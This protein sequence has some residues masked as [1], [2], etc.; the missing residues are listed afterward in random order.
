MLHVSRRV[1]ARVTAQ[2]AAQYLLCKRWRR[3]YIAY[4]KSMRL[5]LQDGP[6]CLR[7]AAGPFYYFVD[8]VLVMWQLGICCIYLIFVAENI[9]QVR[10]KPLF[11]THSLCYLSLAMKASSKR[12]RSSNCIASNKIYLVLR[13]RLLMKKE[14]PQL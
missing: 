1:L 3:G 6:P 5:A 9:K 12:E 4:P 8:I 2:I 13:Y 11:V 14:T 10:A 7:W